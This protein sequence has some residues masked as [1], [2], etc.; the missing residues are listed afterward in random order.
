MARTGLFTAG[1]RVLY[2]P[3]HAHGDVTH[4]DCEP[5]IV[6]SV[7][8][9]WVFVAYGERGRGQVQA[10]HPRQLLLRSEFDDKQNRKVRRAVS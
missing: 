5:G 4:T 7:N 1:D 6:S 10:T 8:D 2:V 3:D 9:W